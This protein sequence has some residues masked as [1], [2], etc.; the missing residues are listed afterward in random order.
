VLEK[1]FR[2]ISQHIATKQLARRIVSIPRRRTLKFAA[3][4]LVAA[5]TAIFT[6]CS[7]S[8]EPEDG[9]FFVHLRF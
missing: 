5:V 6:G 1:R 7:K 8:T 2:A 4:T 9:V 3:A